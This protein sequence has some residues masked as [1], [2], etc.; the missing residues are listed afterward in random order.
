MIHGGRAGARSARASSAPSSS[1]S[2]VCSAARAAS[3]SPRWSNHIEQVRPQRHADRRAPDV[4]G[5]RRARLSGRRSAAPFG[6][7]IFTVNLVGISVLR[8]MGILLTAIIVAG[9]SGSA[10]TAQIG[11]MQVNEEVDAMRTLGLDP[12]EVLVLPRMMALMIAMPLLTFFA[13]M[14]GIARR[15][16]D[17]DGA[18][19]H[20]A[21]RSSSTSCSQAVALWTLLGRHDQGAGVRLPDRAWSAASRACR[22]TGSAESVGR[23]T[24]QS[25][26]ESHLPRHRLR[27][28]VLDPVLVYRRSDWRESRRQRRCRSS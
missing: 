5:R 16:A 25:V 8:E 10:F 13:D 3:A 12:I 7:E 24:T 15:R 20:V 23:R 6:A 26:V 28:R 19:R 9:R 2:R 11:T 27:R 18:D 1:R 4:P 22:V 17:G 14:M 21:R